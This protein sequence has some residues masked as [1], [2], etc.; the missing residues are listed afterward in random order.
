MFS[1]LPALIVIVRS[2]P[3]LLR[4]RDF[5]CLGQSEFQIKRLGTR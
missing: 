5:F 1:G 2:P 3:S 4:T